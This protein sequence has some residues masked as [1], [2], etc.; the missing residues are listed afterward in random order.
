MITF[1]EEQLEV[2][3]AALDETRRLLD[4]EVERAARERKLAEEKIERLIAR[5]RSLGLE[6]DP[7]L[8][9]GGPGEGN[10]ASG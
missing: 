8:L 7:D 4:E 6:P 1:A 9:A 3:E 10:Q 2:V 5:M